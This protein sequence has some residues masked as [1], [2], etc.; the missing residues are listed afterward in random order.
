[1]YEIKRKLILSC[2]QN[3]LRKLEDICFLA[4]LEE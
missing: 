4:V 2:V 1:M 3:K